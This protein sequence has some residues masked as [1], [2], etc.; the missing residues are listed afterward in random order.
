MSWASRVAGSKSAALA[1]APAPQPAPPKLTT[2]AP[3]DEE[4]KSLRHACDRLWALDDNRLVIGRDV[5]LNLQGK[6]FRPS[7]LSDC[8]SQPLF[9]SIDPSVWRRP[10]FA[11]FGALLDNYEA[12]CGR[13]EQATQQERQEETAFLNA[14]CVTRCMQYAHAFLVANGKAPRDEQA[15]R[16]L[17]HKL[18]FQ[19]YR[20][21]S[22]GP[23]DSSGFEH[24]FVGEVKEGQVI[25][26]HNWIQ[27]LVEESKKT[28][29]YKGY[30]PPRRS[31]RPSAP[32]LLLESPHLMTIM[33]TWHAVAK[34][35]GSN[36]IAVSPEF[37]LALCV[38][39]APPTPNTRARARAVDQ[40]R[41]MPAALALAQH[42]ALPQ[43]HYGVSAGGRGQALG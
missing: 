9:A 38:H 24:V 8:A 36:F 35:L 29:D 15:W 39:T 6:K 17:L 7:D 34:T 41:A 3:T 5:V 21:T 43:V 22:G 40:H 23:I 27:I 11:C 30:Y 10:T 26:C 25:G 1:P 32:G 28:L 33:F 14:V 2:P 42:D 16:S 31:K 4:V 18:W 19:M 13:A 37:E 12:L 20:R